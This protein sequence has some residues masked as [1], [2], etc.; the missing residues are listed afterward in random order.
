MSQRTRGGGADRGFSYAAL[1]P[2]LPHHVPTGHAENPGTQRHHPLKTERQ[3]PDPSEH[4]IDRAEDVAAMAHCLGLKSN[5]ATV[6][7][8]LEKMKSVPSS[9]T[10]AV[11]ALPSS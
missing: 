1:A 8:C 11:L 4:A 3:E 7:P 6:S 5:W 2:S 9:E 10:K